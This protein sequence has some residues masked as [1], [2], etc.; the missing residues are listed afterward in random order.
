MSTA[1]TLRDV[2]ELIEGIRKSS[3]VGDTRVLIG[4]PIFAVSPDLWQELGADGSATSA[5]A[6][7]T[8]GKALVSD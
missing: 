6:A 8:V 2:G 7:A 4:G 1:L 5:T 3:S